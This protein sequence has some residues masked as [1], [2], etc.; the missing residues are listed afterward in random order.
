MKSGALVLVYKRHEGRKFAEQGVERA[1]LQMR[2][3]VESEGS[4]LVAIDSF[5][6]IHDLFRAASD[7]A[8]FD[9]GLP[10]IDGHEVGLRARAGSS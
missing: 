5:K 8:F 9:I 7:I 4:D 2:Q 1:L 10:G 3:C 6:A